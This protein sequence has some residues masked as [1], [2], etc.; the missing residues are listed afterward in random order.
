MYI[1]NKK[2]P[3]WA[4][5][6]RRMNVRRDSVYMYGDTLFNPSGGEIPDDV[7]VHERVHEKQQEG[8]DPKIWWIKYLNNK[9]FR[10]RMEVEAFGQQYNWVF[11]QVDKETADL[12]LKDL[13]TTLYKNY[14]LDITQERCYNLIKQYERKHM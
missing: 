7:I 3:N 10:L 11:N 4:E 13:S 14:K 6:N 12:C 8:Q 5:I 2:P 9:D 1:A